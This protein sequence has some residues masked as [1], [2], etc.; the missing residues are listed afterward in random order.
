M[1]SPLLSEITFGSYLVYSPRGS[2][3]TSVRSRRV[4][5]AIKAGHERTIESVIAHLVARFEASGLGAVLGQ[6]VTLVPAPRSSILVPGGLWPSRLLAEE[7]V[8]A[9][10]GCQVLL[11]LTRTA[12]VPKSAFQ[13]PGGRPSARRHY[14]TMTASPDLAAT[15]RITLVDDFVTKGSTLLGGVSR[16]AEVYPRAQLGAFALVRTRGLQRDVDHL[17]EPCVGSVVLV[18]TDD[19]DREP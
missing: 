19:A 14:D 4:R 2:S 9:R 10:L 18:G 17:V 5:D 3:E 7:L 6:D 1:P 16:L 15:T 8:R 13:A 12:A 11:S